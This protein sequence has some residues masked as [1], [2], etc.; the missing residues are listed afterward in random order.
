MLTDGSFFQSLAIV[1][2]T[3]L[4]F[5]RKITTTSEQTGVPLSRKKHLKEKHDGQEKGTG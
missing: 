2:E 4:L 3:D 5:K 1:W